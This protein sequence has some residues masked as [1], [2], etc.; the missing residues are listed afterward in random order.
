MKATLPVL[1]IALLAAVP[2]Y[3]QGA[4][5]ASILTVQSFVLD[6]KGTVGHLTLKNEGTKKIT[7]YAVRSESDSTVQLLYDYY[8]MIGLRPVSDWAPAAPP[9]EAGGVKPGALTERLVTFHEGDKIP[10]LRVSAVVFADRT[11]LGD[12]ADISAVF[13]HRSAIAAELKGWCAGDPLAGATGTDKDA[14]RAA[15]RRFGDRLAAAEAAAPKDNGGGWGGVARRFILSLTN[16][17]R[18]EI[19]LEEHEGARLAWAV[20]SVRR[21]CA[22]AALHSTRAAGGDQ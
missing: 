14:D 2:A 15:L 8:P 19:D 13:Q 3:A 6:P 16:E 17:R 1:G 20:D 9:Y 12:E 4:D 21:I 18:P 11:A 22:S 7:A 5:P 10:A